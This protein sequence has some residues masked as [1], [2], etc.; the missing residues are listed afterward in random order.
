MTKL[1]LMLVLV[2][3]AAVSGSVGTSG[4]SVGGFERTL[5]VR[6]DGGSGRRM[7]KCVRTWRTE[8]KERGDGDG[9]NRDGLG[10]GDGGSEVRTR[11]HCE[12]VRL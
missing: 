8:R 1:H 12:R 10:R 11:N 4:A 7:R 3:A 6:G 9:R 5:D 2:L